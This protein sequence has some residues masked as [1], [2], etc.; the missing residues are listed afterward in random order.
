MY[1]LAKTEAKFADIIWDNEPLPSGELVRLCLDK[2]N[3][4]KSTTYTM[5]K[6]LCDRGIFINDGGTVRSLILRE[7][8]KT[9]QSRQFV[10]DKFDGSL[11]GFIAAFAGREKLSEKEVKEII[12]IIEGYRR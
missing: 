9:E 6:R 8:F 12:D 4:K 5:L 10:R 11:P 7:D 2:L 1:N 3:W